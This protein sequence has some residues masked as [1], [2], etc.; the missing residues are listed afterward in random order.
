M[1]SLSFLFIQNVRGQQHSLDNTLEPSL[2]L[3]GAGS[4]WAARQG[5]SVLFVNWK[6]NWLSH[7][8][9]DGIDWYYDPWIKYM[10]DFRTSI[11]KALNYANLDIEYAGDIPS[12]L[13]EYDLILIHAWF[14]AEPHH[15]SII[16]DYIKDGGGVVI[17]SSVP[18]YFSTYCKD[19]WPYR[20][21]GTDLTS[22]QDWFGAKNYW[23]TG[24]SASIVVDRPF[25]T[26]LSYDDVVF[27]VGGDSNA[28][29]YSLSTN[30]E[31]I[32]KWNT[33]YVHCSPF[34]GF[35]SSSNEKI[36]AFTHEYGKG[37][38]YYQA[39]FEMDTDEDIFVNSVSVEI[40]PKLDLQP[41][42]GISQT[43]IQG[44]GFAPN[45]GIIVT[46]NEIHMYTIPYPLTTDGYGNFT[47]MVSVINQTQT[48]PYQITAVDEIK[49]Q[50][51]STFNVI[52]EFTSWILFPLFIVTSAVVFVSRH[53][54]RKNS[55]Q[56]RLV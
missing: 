28:F 45:S 40:D 41:T 25:D 35:P 55:G 12:S 19:N 9:T 16:R 52:P 49:N 27:S 23:S 22:I 42:E 26:P 53:H 24:G 51:T 11:T 13:T 4:R 54:L 36:F 50:A 44:S 14:A 39:H 31:I 1:N 32:A 33:D 7:S 46:W 18:C 3:L 21:D 29:V 15:V 20:V 56:K 8:T 34:F 43:T 2:Q 37:R 38:V 6:D 17:M 5:N 47:A 48:G 30:S 10:D